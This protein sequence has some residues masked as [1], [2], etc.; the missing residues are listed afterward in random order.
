[1][2]TNEVIR[3]FLVGKQRID[4]RTEFKEAM[5]RGQ[6]GVLI[7][8]ICLAYIF[9]DSFNGVTKFFSFYFLGIAVSA[10][11]VIMNRN[12]KSTSASV[13]ILLFSNFLVFSFAAIDSPFSGVFLF[14]TATAAVALIL[15]ARHDRYVGFLFAGLSVLLGLVAYF[16]DWSPIDAL[17]VT[18]Y[19]QV[20]FITNYLLGMVCCILVIHFAISRNNESEKSLMNNIKAREEAEHALIIKNEELEKANKELDRF[21]YS[22]SHDMRAP[23]SSLLGLIEI[24]RLT[25]KDEELN[26]YF[27]LMKKRILTMEGFIKEIT[28]YSRNSRTEV[29]LEEIKLIGLVREVINSIEFISLSAS[30]ESRV[31]IPE[32]FVVRSDSSRLKVV[33]TNV[34]SNCIK[35]HNAKTSNKWY[36]IRAREEGEFY[37]VEVEDNGI[38]IPDEYQEKIYDMFFRAT[39]SSEGSGLGLYIV[40]ETIEKLNGTIQCASKLGLGT[41]FTIA[42]PK[43][44]NGLPLPSASVSDIEKF[45][46][47]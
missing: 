1:M 10:I 9:I 25:N 19:E 30:I 5:L 40:K 20:S 8:G 16:I 29:N 43:Q 32:D 45:P 41:T 31:D 22:A 35:Y 28:D 18:D 47:H 2:A 15:F 4:S 23:L 46:A 39:E 34:I 24:V 12:R 17:P 37:V 44:D 3:D 14:F 33:L 27:G 7:G 11:I 21:V 42:F 13:M 38:G 26:E 6:F 36:S